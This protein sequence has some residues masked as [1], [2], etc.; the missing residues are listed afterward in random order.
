MGAHDDAV[1]LK[2]VEY[3]REQW[4]WWDRYGGGGRHILFQTGEG[5]I[6]VNVADKSDKPQYRCIGRK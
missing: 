5:F 4:P 1:A 6:K 2:A 3:I